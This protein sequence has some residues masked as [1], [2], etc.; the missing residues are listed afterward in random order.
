MSAIRLDDEFDH[1]YQCLIYALLQDSTSQWSLNFLA[2]STWE[3][4]PSSQALITPAQCR[5]WWKQFDMETEYMVNQ[6]IFALEEA[7]RH[8]AEAIRPK[9]TKWRWVPQ[10][11]S[12]A[13]VALTA[14]SMAV[15][16]PTV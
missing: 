7:T 9:K 16:L 11:A 4:V 8:N 5:S 12:V 13:S 6:A 14:V 15:G 1:I 10:A 3:L 2:S